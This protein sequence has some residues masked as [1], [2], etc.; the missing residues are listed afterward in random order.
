MT[1]NVVKVKLADAGAHRQPLAPKL[2]VL[3]AFEFFLDVERIPELN[4]CSEAKSILSSSFV[5]EL[6]GLRTLPL[7]DYR[8][9]MSL[10]RR[11]LFALAN[12]L[13]RQESERKT[14]FERYVASHPVAQD[15]A[16]FRAKTER[17]APVTPAPTEAKPAIVVVGDPT[18]ALS[19]HVLV[20]G[21]MDE[22]IVQ[23]EPPTSVNSD[24]ADS[25]GASE[26]VSS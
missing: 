11:V 3:P 9:L 5:T 10:K 18:A 1:K 6:Q 24:D 8:R 4:D 2:R 12:W 15:Y 21:D 20:D 23:P 14:S 17:E 26:P 7:V 13:S 16:A 25:S 22:Q 19:E